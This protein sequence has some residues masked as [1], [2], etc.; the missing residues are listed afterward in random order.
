[1]K[2][3]MYLPF[4]ARSFSE[5]ELKGALGVAIPVSGSEIVWAVSGSTFPSI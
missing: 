2:Y 4:I 3:K 5:Y 1:M